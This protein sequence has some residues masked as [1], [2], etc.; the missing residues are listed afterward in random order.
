MISQFLILSPRGDPLILRDYLGNIPKVRGRADAREGVACSMRT[1]PASQPGE[2]WYQHPPVGPCH[3]ALA[4][5]NAQGSAEVFFRKVK[6][7]DG[8]GGRDAPPVFNV[9]GIN[10][11]HLKVR[12]GSEMVFTSSGCAG[13]P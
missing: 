1:Q 2:Q 10:Y 7:W 4:G 5:A 3:A 8:E 9:D 6:F 13:P 11:M 12:Q